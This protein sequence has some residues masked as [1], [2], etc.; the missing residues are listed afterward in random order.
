MVFMVGQ[1]AIRFRALAF[2]NFQFVAQIYGGDA[3]QF[4]LSLDATLD[5]GFQ[6][7]C[8]GDSARFQRAGKC[9]GQSTSQGGDDV[10]D[11]GR[12]RRDVLH[13]VILGVSAVRA[14]VQRLLKSLDVRVAERTLLLNQ[15]DARGVN[16]FAHE[17]V[18]PG[19]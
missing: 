17:R 15:P 2:R 10:I 11:G 18:P 4:F 19:T 1:C 8:C 16:D 14:E 5:F 3:K 9:A 7:V 12:Q 13:A 6:M